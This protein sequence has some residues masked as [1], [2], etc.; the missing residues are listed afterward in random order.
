MIKILIKDSKRFL[1]LNQ[2]YLIGNFFSFY[3]PA[4][5]KIK[6]NDLYD[7]ILTKLRYGDS[8]GKETH[9]RRFDELDE[10]LD[11]LPQENI[12]IHDVGCSSGV[13]SLDLMRV[14]NSK[15]KSYELII[16]DRF[17]E[18]LVYGR[19]IKYL[20]DSD[21]DLR[22]IYFGRILCDD[23]LSKNFFMSRFLFKL[24]RSFSQGD[25]KSKT[26]KKISLFN[27]EV[28][29]SISSKNLKAMSYNIFKQDD[30]S[31]YGFI[32][33]MN[34]LNRSYFSDDQINIGISNLFKSMDHNAYLQIGRTDDRGINRAS[35]FRKYEQ[36]LSLVLQFNG[37]S[38]IEDLVII[39]GKEF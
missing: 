33:C 3:I 6:D 10:V 30:D 7:I 11:L 16:S 35:I 14:L 8:T 34:L 20:Y 32:R 18:L 31:K 36:G 2:V 19:N 17:S 15:N 5:N 38:E 29:K 24:L 26:I 22:Q 23:Q 9:K 37:G 25:P 28:Q 21:G 27:R 1:W 12:L 4:L 39:A 13:T